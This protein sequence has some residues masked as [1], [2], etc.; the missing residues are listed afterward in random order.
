MTKSWRRRF[1]GAVA[2]YLLLWG[3]TQ[4]VGAARVRATVA[5]EYLPRKACP[6]LP[7][8]ECHASAVAPL[9]VTGDW[10][11]SSV[12]LEGG[13]ARFLYALFGPFSVKLWQRQTIVF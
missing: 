2:I 5:N 4:V 11:W 3:L 8:C 7:L 10:I 13:G 9:L 6:R 1:L 12:S